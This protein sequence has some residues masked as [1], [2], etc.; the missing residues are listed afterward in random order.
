MI[1]VVKSSVIMFG[2]ISKFPINPTNPISYFSSLEK[3]MVIKTVGNMLVTKT[4]A[5][6]S[7]V[8]NELQAKLD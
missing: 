6:N 5:R 7:L 2:K 4:K 1:I 8:I 3:R